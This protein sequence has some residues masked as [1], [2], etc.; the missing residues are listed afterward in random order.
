[1]VCDREARFGAHLSHCRVWPA[2]PCS[3]TPP[4]PPL[5]PR[6]SPD[7]HETRLTGQPQRSRSASGAARCATRLRKERSSSR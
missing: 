3:A 7:C 4:L 5:P 2:G 1:V 6:P